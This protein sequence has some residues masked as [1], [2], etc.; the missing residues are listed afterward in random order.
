VTPP[1]QPLLHQ[2]PVSNADLAETLREIVGERGVLIRPHELLVYTSDGLPGYR[3]QPALAVF[4]TSGQQVIAVVHALARAKRPFVPRGA[5]T[6]LSGGA[7]GEG[8]AVIL[9]LNRM[10]RILEID[11]ANQ[12][13]TVEPGVVN[14]AL[15][16]ATS[17]FGLHYAPD[18]SSQTACTIGGNLAE[19]AGGP[20]CLKY[21]VTLN[22]VVAATVVLPDGEVVR[23][24]NA[25]GEDVGYDLLGLFVGSEGCFGVA[26]DITVRLARNPQ[27]VR[28]L[29]AD[30]MSI[31]AA[32]RATTAIVA[33][34]IVPAALEMMDA[35]TIRA[36]EASI[37]AAGYPVDAEAV[38]LVEVDGL[39]AGVDADVAIIE[40]LC[41]EAGA[42][43]VRIAR[44]A[45]ERARLWQGRKKA[46][47]AMGRLAPHLVVQDAVVP[48][49]KLA[50]VMGRIREIGERHRVRVCNVFH[51]GDGNL[52]PNI[53]Y[54]A[55]NA[56]EREHVEMAMREIMDVCVNAGGTITGE[57][58][59]G[60]DKLRYMERIFS[61]DSLAA[62]CSV[63][64]VFDPNR[65]ANPGK[66]VPMHSCREWLGTPGIQP[67][68]SV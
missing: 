18:P 43:T 33:S 40:S 60:L 8:D 6:G 39:S 54:D 32:A 46:F 31:D 26:I 7:L 19:N 35:P 4:P 50:E 45:A 48:R 55:A 64:D 25:R 59:V 66:V 20:H 14:A 51:A 63:R 52:H 57:H 15:T 13:A 34:G 62:M 38:L 49:T 24:G 65:R 3:K 10:T 37:Y 17:E 28:T 56:D 47:G 29:L 67:P 61:A 22:H 23:L 5:G 36:V 12:L 53:P 9:G 58:G 21:G 68:F 30:F 16:R 44:D 1:T 41:R 27:S 11:A 42:R 2:S